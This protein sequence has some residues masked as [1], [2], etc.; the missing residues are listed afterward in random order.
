MVFIP[1]IQI[2]RFLTGRMHSWAF[3]EFIKGNAQFLFWCKPR[4][5]GAWGVCITF[6]QI[7]QKIPTK[8]IFH[9]LEL[10][11]EILSFLQIFSVRKTIT[12]LF[13]ISENL[14]DDQQKNY[15]SFRFWAFETKWQIIYA[16]TYYFFLTLRTVSLYV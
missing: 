12:L 7:T 8:D 16:A 13:N 10:I 15:I 3:W 4:K 11:T 14:L 2:F 9:W 1:T 5:S 6:P